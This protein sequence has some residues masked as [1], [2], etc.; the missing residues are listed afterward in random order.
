[1]APRRQTGL[2]SLATELGVSITTVSRALA[3]YDDVSAE[4]RARV[5]AAASERGYVP[6]R[7]GR[8]LVS[9]R[10]DFIGMVLPMR[11][12]HLIDAFLGE[13]VAGLSGGL[14]EVGRD[15][16]LATAT[17]EQTE[18]EVLRHIVDGD[19]A[20]AIVLNRTEYDD[21]RVNFLVRRRFPFVAHGRCLAGAQ[22]PVWFDTDG[23][24]AFAQAAERLIALGH[25]RFG[26]VTISEPLTFA[27]LRR[28]GLERALSLAGL[29]LAP[30]SV[31]AASMSDAA[32][33]L[34]A[35]R[36]LLTMD[37]RPTAI[38]G[39]TDAQA[40][41]VLEVAASLSISVPRDLSVIGF[42]DVPVAA[43]AS[44]GLS[45]F[46]QHARESANIVAGM[47]IDVL[48]R[49]TE[50]VQSRLIRPQF[51]ARGSHGPAPD[52]KTAGRRRRRPE[53]RGT[54]QKTQGRK[55]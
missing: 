14:A 24:A 36:R 40:L 26:L 25:R 31:V 16:F 1:V 54:T 11:G 20:D 19:R 50:R 29:R 45:T 22:P 21:A 44:P 43:Y 47:A 32:S 34:A 53:A 23:E 27:H 12:G 35:A 2:K 39:I 10:T 5:Q 37:E 13:F 15:L 6:S 55:T 28:R 38:L 8:M 9:G 4:T 3:G 52:T 51:M 46:D 42:D 48:E 49:G 30:E 33:A 17:G 7:V 41:A 18:I